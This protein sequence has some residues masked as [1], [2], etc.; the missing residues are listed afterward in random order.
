M[1]STNKL[2]CLMLFSCFI[3]ACTKNAENPECPDNGNEIF[4]DDC[5]PIPNPPEFFQ[6]WPMVTPDV[7]I[8]L[9]ADVNPENND[10]FCILQQL[11]PGNE[12]IIIYTRSTNQVEILLQGDF[13]PKINWM[14]DEWI[15]FKEAD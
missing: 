15:I 3:G 11:G 9:T 6:Q 12:Q 1:K 14:V 8:N 10:Q 5:V 7:V 2:I 4:K 13:S